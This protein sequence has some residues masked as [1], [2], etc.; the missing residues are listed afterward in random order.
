MP[1]RIR[2]AVIV[3]LLAF[4]LAACSAQAP[5]PV[6]SAAA[7]NRTDADLTSAML[8]NIAYSYADDAWYPFLLTNGTNLDINVTDGFLVVAT[9]LPQTDTAQAASICSSIAAITNDSTTAEPLGITGVDI[10]SGGTKIAG[11]KP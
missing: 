6:G 11:C 9:L 7:P 8:S 4:S 2:P 10:I 3:G 1:H 5:K